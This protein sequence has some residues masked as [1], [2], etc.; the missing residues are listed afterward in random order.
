MNILIIGDS[1]AADWT[2]KYPELIGWP[3][4]LEKDHNVTNLAQAGVG[5]YKILRQLETLTN[6]DEYDL[7]IIS[8]T[9]PYRVNTRF[10]PVHHDDILHKNADLIYTDIEYHKGR[11]KNIFN[12]SLRTAFKYFLYHF[13]T[14]YQERVYL[15]IKDEI[16]RILKNK[17]TLIISNLDLK[18]FGLSDN[19]IIFID[20]IQNKHPGLANHLSYT[21][22]KLVYEKI[23]NFINTRRIK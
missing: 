23:I 2:V 10:H 13:D 22:N 4:L 6:L 1:F 9:S 8:H 12:R 3:N 5:E 21:G 16:H 14:E 19:N 20:Q 7:V 11:L 15:L 17:N 18:S